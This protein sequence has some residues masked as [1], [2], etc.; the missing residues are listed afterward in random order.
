[1][2]PPIYLDYNATTPILPEALDAMLPHLRD[3]FGN[4]SSDHAFGHR[5]RAAVDRARERVAAFLGCDP[6]EVIFTSGGTEANNLAIRGVAEAAGNRR[7][8]VT[9]AIEHPATANPCAW[10]SR[11]GWRV[12]YAGVDQNGVTRAGDVRS[13]LSPDTALVTVMHANNETGVLQPVREIAEWAHAAGAVVHTD[14]AQSIGKVRF[15]VRE[16]GVDL[17][18]VAG[19]KVYAP[20]GV[21]ALYVRRGT[22]LVPF[23]LGASHE[24]GLRPGTENVASIAGLGAALERIGS[25]LESSAARVRGLRDELWDLLRSRIPGIALNGHPDLRL[26]NTLSVRFPGVSARPLLERVPQIAASAGSACHAG[27]DVPSSVITAMGVAPE[28]A[29]GS[30]R[31]TLGRPTTPQDIHDAA[32]ALATGWTALR[33]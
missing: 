14:A 3:G 2:K 29:V 33:A 21:G 27:E 20:K 6:D 31:L 5:A 4:P 15:T 32:D 9:T 18:S 1:M 19:H 25:D 24:R 7:H 8:L 23:A 16:L 10:L 12:T 11:H 17:L 26:P 28:A 13:A 30:I 22:S